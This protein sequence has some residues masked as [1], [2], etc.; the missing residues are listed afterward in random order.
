MARGWE[1][2]SVEDQQA[3]V[4]AR[5]APSDRP[6]LTPDERAQADRRDLLSLARARVLQDLQGA[7]DRRRRSQLEAALE[8]IETQLA[9]VGLAPKPSG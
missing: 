2:K 7:C 5:R 8:D 6:A 3:E 1:S 4:E 9:A